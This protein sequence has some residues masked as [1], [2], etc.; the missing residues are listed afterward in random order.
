MSSLLDRLAQVKEKAEKQIREATVSAEAM[1]IS[2]D[3]ERQMRELAAAGDEDAKA[4]L[5]DIEAAR[6][7]GEG[8]KPA[9]AIKAALGLMTK[10]GNDDRLRVSAVVLEAIELGALREGEP[11]EP[12]SVSVYDLDR[13]QVVRGCAAF[14]LS[15]TKSLVERLREYMVAQ[16]EALIQDLKDGKVPPQVAAERAVELRMGRVRPWSF[17]EAK[18][19]EAAKAEAEGSKKKG[20]PPYFRF[21]YRVTKEDGSEARDSAIISWER[22]RPG[23]RP[24]YSNEK[25]LEFIGLLHSEAKRQAELLKERL[26]EFTLDESEAKESGNFSEILAGRVG[27]AVLQLETVWKYS[28]G[29]E[30]PIF[31]KVARVTEKESAKFVKASPVEAA[32]SLFRR[33]DG[34]LRAVQVECRFVRDERNRVVELSFEGIRDQRLRGASQR[35][36]AKEANMPLVSAVRAERDAENRVGLLKFREEIVAE[37]TITRGEYLAGKPGLLAVTND[38]WKLG[39]S[40][41]TID[42]VDGLLKSDGKDVSVVKLSQPALKLV[43]EGTMPT[44]PRNRFQVPGRIHA[45]IMTAEENSVAAEDSEAG[46]ATAVTTVSAGER[47]AKPQSSSPGPQVSAREAAFR[48][49]KVKTPRGKKRGDNRPKMGVEPQD[50]LEG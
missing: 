30:E 4:L 35:R 37:A 3:D 34:Q 24:P 11:G 5:S 1:R 17:I 44:E 36:A 6:K 32:R 33:S 41:K 21:T 2:P 7:A 50:E 18:K 20:W 13:G 45:W 8:S 29:R 16:R 25:S 12:D 19:A 43:F 28:D 26:P 40:E 14:G 23:F 31:V 27:E 9:E 39:R 38:R 15:E 22:E 48:D 47:A 42:L 49:A 46:G 10:I